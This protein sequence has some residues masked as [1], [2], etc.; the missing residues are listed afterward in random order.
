MAS[1]EAMGSDY[2][3]LIANSR[4]KMFVESF[5]RTKDRPSTHILIAILKRESLEIKDQKWYFMTHGRHQPYQKT[6]AI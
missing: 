3:I 2:A 1:R 5:G 6:I 4:Q